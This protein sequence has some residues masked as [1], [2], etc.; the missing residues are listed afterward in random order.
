MRN[1]EAVDRAYVKK[2][3]KEGRRKKERNEGRECGEKR[4]RI[5]GKGKRKGPSVK[6]F[7][8]EMNNFASDRYLL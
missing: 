6:G 1:R 2:K 8:H 3:T 4:R 5:R 7:S